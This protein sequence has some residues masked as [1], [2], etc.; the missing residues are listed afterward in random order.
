MQEY[1][2]QQIVY[3][4]ADLSFQVTVRAH[5]D[6]VFCVPMATGGTLHLAASLDAVDM[7]SELLGLYR[8]VEFLTCGGMGYIYT[9]TDQQNTAKILKVTHVCASAEVHALTNEFNLMVVLNHPNI[10]QVYN[11]FSV[12]QVLGF[13]MKV[14]RFGDVHHAI[15]QRAFTPLQTL[16]LACEILSGLAFIHLSQLVH[17]DIKPS[18][19]LFDSGYRAVISDFGLAI[20]VHKIVVGEINGTAG[21]IAPEV[22]SCMKYDTQ[23]DIWSFIRTVYA[24]VSRKPNY[25]VRLQYDLVPMCLRELVKNADYENP[26]HRK[27]ARWYTL[28]MIAADLVVSVK[29]PFHYRSL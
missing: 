5:A 29:F 6:V 14:Y 23:S 22:L 10:A 20:D 16:A 21:Y 25:P 19:I 4:S 24:V 1:V 26:S 28:A 27:P 11:D 9:A 3:G 13:E 2:H 17:R 7:K 18:N 8:N 12:N 15:M